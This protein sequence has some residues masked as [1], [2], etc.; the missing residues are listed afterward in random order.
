MYKSQ[1]GTAF[2]ADKESDCFLSEGILFFRRV[3]TSVTH[4]VAFLAILSPELFRFLGFYRLEGL[5]VRGQHLYKP[6]DLKT[7]QP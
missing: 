3:C 6:S 7:S 2:Q 4:G 5:E 1:S